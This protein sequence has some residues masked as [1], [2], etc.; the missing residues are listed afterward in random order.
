[1]T[2]LC[3][4]QISVDIF[5]LCKEGAAGPPLRLRPESPAGQHQA[6][7]SLSPV[8]SAHGGT[9]R[10]YGASSRSPYLLSQPSAPLQLLVSGE[11]P[12][13][14]PSASSRCLRGPEARR[15]WSGLE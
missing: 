12:D 4:S 14:V 2:L 6:G 10:C 1:M 3:Q 15:A 8:T 11:R 13:P 5:L 9:Y 7:F